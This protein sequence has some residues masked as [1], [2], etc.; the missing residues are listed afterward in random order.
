MKS[1]MFILLPPTPMFIAFVLTLGYS[2]SW[3]AG[4]AMALA[5][6]I[7]WILATLACFIGGFVFFRRQRRL[8]WC[9]FAVVLLQVILAILPALADI[10]VRHSR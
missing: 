3:D 4:G 5:V 7:L 1:S 9:C 2:R 8:A 6:F 10:N